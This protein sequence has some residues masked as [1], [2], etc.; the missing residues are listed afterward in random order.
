MKFIVT[1]KTPDVLDEAIQEEVQSQ[2]VQEL[3]EP[4][5]DDANKLLDRID[6]ES[7]EQRIEEIKDGLCKRWFKH[8]EYLTVEIDTEAETCVVVP[9]EE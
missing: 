4:D 3:D 1:M 8:E 6:E 7:L 2:M 5:C 9:C